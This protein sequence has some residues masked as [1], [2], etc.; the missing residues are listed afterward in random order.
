MA[1]TVVTVALWGQRLT[2]ADCGGICQGAGVS[3]PATGLFG[4]VGS[5][6]PDPQKRKGMSWKLAE[7]TGSPGCRVSGKTNSKF[8]ALYCPSTSPLAQSASP[9]GHRVVTLGRGS[10]RG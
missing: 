9:L 3:G 5:K 6:R 2:G 7:T 4:S 1:W 8:G 10:N